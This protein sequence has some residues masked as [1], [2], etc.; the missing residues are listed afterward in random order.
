MTMS[1]TI[2]KNTEHERTPRDCNASRKETAALGAFR[3]GQRVKVTLDDL[4]TASGYD[5]SMLSRIERGHRPVK[6]SEVKRLRELISQ[7]AARKWG[8]QLVP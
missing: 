6:R 7:I 1:M 4:A 2:M 5:T 3:R 8:A